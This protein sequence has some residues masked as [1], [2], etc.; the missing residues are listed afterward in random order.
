LPSPSYNLELLSSDNES[1]HEHEGSV[2]PMTEHDYPFPPNHITEGEIASH[3]IS[4][5]SS[6]EVENA[7]QGN[8]AID[9][10]CV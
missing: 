9:L 10:E 2:D 5:D 8:E 1:D 3:E 6:I 7:L 4:I